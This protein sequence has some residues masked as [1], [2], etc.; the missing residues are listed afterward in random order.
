MTPKPK[1]AF[2]TVIDSTIRASFVECPKKFYWSFIRKLGPKE[3]SAD[4][5][6][7]GSFAKGLE[8][9]R[10]LFYLEGHDKFR[11]MEYG[12]A[13]AIEEYGDFECPPHKANKSLDRVIEALGYYFT[14]WPLDTDYIKPHKWD[15]GGGIE[16]TFSL[17]M[18]LAHPATGEPL[19]YAGRCDMIAEYNQQLWVVDEKTTSQLGATWA[20]KWNLRSQFT[21]YVKAAQSFGLP[22]AG[23]IIRGVSFLK[24]SNDHAEAMTARPQWMIDRW[25]EQ[26]HRDV[27]RMLH[28]WHEEY[29]DYNL[30]ES[31]NAYGGCP[32][33]RLCLTPEPEAWIEGNYGTRDWN[34]LAKQPQPKMPQTDWPIPPIPLQD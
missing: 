8:V 16:F 27:E 12:I 26:L 11:A 23:A 24:R 20:D 19:V 22:V 7:G 18:E 6:A 15:G 1:E 28:C 32:F 25:W 29:F 31:C 34:P 13:A 14:T 2:P 3:G 4:L 9:A 10:K 17:P 30:D 21:G 5:I 33:S